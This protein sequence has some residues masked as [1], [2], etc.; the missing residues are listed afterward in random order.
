MTSIQKLS[1][2]HTIEYSYFDCGSEKTVVLLHGL[3]GSAELSFEAKEIAKQYHTNLLTFARAGYGRSSNAKFHSVYEA[4]QDGYDLL[5]LLEID[6]YCILAVSAGCPYGLAFQSFVH[7]PDNTVIIS[8]L[9]AVYSVDVL[10]QYS[11]AS[12]LFFFVFKHAP[13]SLVSSILKSIVNQ[14]KEVVGE[15]DSS[16]QASLANERAGLLRE[17]KLQQKNWGF[18]VSKLSNIQWLHGKYDEQVP[19]ATVKQTLSFMSGVSLH[20]EEDL[21]HY[22]DI[23]HWHKAF[24]ILVS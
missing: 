3:I 13:K 16:I 1:N 21:K 19:L 7:K 11:L 9:P 22:P 4:A 14:V 5:K 2:G 10:R 15:N 18:D 8:G 23:Q 24:K 6:R 20:I 17:V 12:R